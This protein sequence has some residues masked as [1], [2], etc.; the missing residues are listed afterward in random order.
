MKYIVLFILFSMQLYCTK[1]PFYNVG[2]DSYDSR[3]TI[4]FKSGIYPASIPEL[5]EYDTSKYIVIIFNKYNGSKLPKELFELKNVKQLRI[6]KSTESIDNIIMG[7]NNFPNL[8]Y[9][10][11]DSAKKVDFSLI[12]GRLTKLEDIMIR[13]VDTVVI[14]NSIF[15]DFK[16]ENIDIGIVKEVFFSDDIVM[17]YIHE[18]L[19]SGRAC[20]PMPKIHNIK[21]LLNNVN[22]MYSLSLGKIAIDT[23]LE[24]NNCIESLSLASVVVPKIITTN[25]CFGLKAIELS[26]MGLTDINLDIYHRKEIAWLDLS[27]NKLSNFRFDLLTNHTFEGIPDSIINSYWTDNNTEDHS[28][29]LKLDWNWI[30]SVQTFVDTC[31]KKDYRIS[32]SYNNRTPKPEFAGFEPKEYRDYDYKKFTFSLPKGLFNLQFRGRLELI[33]YTLSDDEKDKIRKH[34]KY[35]EV[36]FEE[37]KRR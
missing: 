21:N 9:L 16:D 7:L 24:S 29:T 1:S 27:R 31:I 22:S 19:I 26:S 33:G 37:K 8:E 28:A 10:V 5:L 11:I 18:I 34:F 6:N 12:P 3:V 20:T 32:L 15:S 14:A 30:D 36:I 23:V 17:P 4:W 2:I 13:T 25:S 35:A